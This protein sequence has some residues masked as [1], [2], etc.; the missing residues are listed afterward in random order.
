ME[1]R[2]RTIAALEAVT[3]QLL[4]P[5]VYRQILDG[6]PDGLVVVDA[7]RRIAFVNRRAQLMLG[8]SSDQLIGQSLSM[9]LP[10]DV[11]GRHD[12]LAEGY[13]LDPIP[14]PM[15]QGRVLQ[16]RHATGRSVPV[17]ISLGAA[18]SAGG[19]LAIA[20]LTAARMS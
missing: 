5:D 16:A 14:R 6:V 12:A 17:T 18:V 2:G 19:T 11:Q 4:T 3:E 13:C 15:S 10:E 1:E 20:T 7:D 8:Y 9:L